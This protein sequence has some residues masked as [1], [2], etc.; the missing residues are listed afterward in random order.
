[1]K[2]SGNNR[3]LP[4]IRG[5]TLTE[6]MVALAVFSLVIAGAMPVYIMC[7]RNWHSTSLSMQ[8][9][10]ETSMALERMV[11]GAGLQYGLRSAV[12]TSVVVSTTGT[13]WTVQYVNSEGMTNFFS[14]SSSQTVLRYLGSGWSD[15]MLIGTNITACVIS[16]SSGGMSISVT[17]GITEGRYS[18]TNTMN[19][20]VSYRN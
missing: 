3:I 11:Y 18:V 4:K 1:M 12:A 15:W 7:N 17:T 2:R 8:A 14:Y 16:N 9:A 13:S 5:F 10:T 6:V 20:Y 19:T